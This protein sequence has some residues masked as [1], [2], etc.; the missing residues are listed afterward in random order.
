MG[1]LCGEWGVV[2]RGLEGMLYRLE[3]WLG[4]PPGREIG[5]EFLE[6]R[7][8]VIR[9]LEMVMEKILWEEKSGSGSL[10]GITLP[11]PARMK[12]T[13]VYY[14]PRKGL[15]SQYLEASMRKEIRGMS[16][17]VDSS[18]SSGDAS[19]SSASEKS[20]KSTKSLPQRYRHHHSMK[21]AVPSTRNNHTTTDNSGHR[22]ESEKLVEEAIVRGEPVT[23][24]NN[25]LL[26]KS[27]LLPSATTK[28]PTTPTTPPSPIPRSAGTSSS[29]EVDQQHYNANVLLTPDPSSSRD[30]DTDVISLRSV[31]T[32]DQK[33][34]F[35]QHRHR[36]RDITPTPTDPF[37]LRKDPKTIATSPSPSPITSAVLGSNTGSSVPMASMTTTPSP[38]KRAALYDSPRW[39]RSGRPSPSSPA[40]IVGPVVQE[41]SVTDGKDRKKFVSNR[42][43]GERGRL[44]EV[45]PAE[46]IWKG[47]DEEYVSP[48]GGRFKLRRKLRRKASVRTEFDE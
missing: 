17:S 5:Q 32:L 3:R 44:G 14:P 28:P 16:R 48:E 18:V 6:M 43:D 26:T 42:I 37:G 13:D 22:K 10:R 40:S 7:G 35:T 23:L 4:R 33:Y 1:G 45:D 12:G 34:P 30:K 2:R 39:P 29:N 24:F 11:P 41:D 31:M 25:A 47:I 21:A 20:I 19:Y 46:A 36:S 27:S 15:Q 9:E 38:R 8:E